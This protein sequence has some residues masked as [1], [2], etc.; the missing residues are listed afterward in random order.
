MP[1]QDG[2]VFLMS[3][4]GNVSVGKG[5]AEAKTTMRFQTNLLVLLQRPLLLLYSRKIELC[6]KPWPR[7]K[8]DQTPVVPVNCV[9]RCKINGLKC[10]GFLPGN[11]KSCLFCLQCIVSIATS[12]PFLSIPL[13][14]FI[15]FPI[16]I[17]VQ[18][19]LRRSLLPCWNNR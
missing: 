13:Y 14:S 17:R 12:F 15:C 3:S 11:E 8:G 6:L 4:A 2:P 18:G 9:R 7:R 19:V 16:T 1:Q 10:R 5:Y